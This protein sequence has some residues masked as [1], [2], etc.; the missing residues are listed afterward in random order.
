[1]QYLYNFLIVFLALLVSHF[2]RPFFGAYAN[3]KGENLA[4]KEDIAQLTKIAEG[5]RAEISDKV[6]DR[7]KQ[8]EMKKEAVLDSL[9]ALADYENASSNLDS[10]FTVRVEN[11]NG[12]GRT[13]LENL[14]CNALS[15]FRK[16]DSEYNRAHIIA[17]L[18]VGGQVSKDLS[19]YIQFSAPIILDA[20]PERRRFLNRPETLK[21][22]AQRRDAVIMSSRE[23]LGI[24]DAGDLPLLV[25]SN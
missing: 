1:M 11:C 24:K 7:Q 9:R 2:I 20:L 6:W 4:T 18:S 21:E 17:D 3:K 13:V 16:C 8:W 22:L 5:I 23:A 19:K 25:E 10:T 14:Q 15:Q 12:D